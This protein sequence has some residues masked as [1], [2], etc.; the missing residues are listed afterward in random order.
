MKTIKE[1]KAEIG[2]NWA[3]HDRDIK[4]KMLKDVLKLIMSEKANHP[5]HGCRIC[6]EFDKL[7][8]MINGEE[9]SEELKSKIQGK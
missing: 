6:E 9:L 3:S 5:E 1:L 2:H 4:I 8:A 7:M